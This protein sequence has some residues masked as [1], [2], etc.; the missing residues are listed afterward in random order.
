MTPPTRHR[1]LATTMTFAA[2]CLTVFLFVSLSRAALTPAQSAATSAFLTSFTT[3]MPGLA[4]LW[5]ASD[6]CTWPYVTCASDTNITLAIDSA[7]LTGSLPALSSS[8]AGGSVMLTTIAITNMNITNG[9][10]DSW[11]GLTHVQVINFTNTNLF[12]TIPATWNAMSALVTL[13]AQNSSACGTLSNYTLRTLREVNVA[14]NYLR[15]P[16]PETWGS[17]TLTELDLNGNNFCGCLP[18]LWLTKVFTTA[19]YQ[20]MG[21][22]PFALLCTTPVNCVQ[23]GEICSRSPPIYRDAAAPAP[24]VAAIAIV[25]AVAAVVGVVAL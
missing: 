6:W 2:L 24:S 8:I 7:G 9:F 4:T 3:T 5:T 12:G 14:D 13:A 17:L 16:L 11:S 20:A 18:P 22:A 1:G 19:V 21:N 15:G 23:E 25:A 10:P